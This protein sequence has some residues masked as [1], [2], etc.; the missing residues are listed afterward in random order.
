MMK[1]EM[2]RLVLVLSLPVLFGSCDTGTSVSELAENQSKWLLQTIHF[3]DGRDLRV[4]DPSKYT[5]RFNP[6][7]TASFRVDCNSCFA[8][9]AVDGNT[10]SIGLMACTLALCPEG[11][12]SDEYVGA[13]SRARSFHRQETVLRIEGGGGDLVFHLE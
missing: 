3:D 13:L 4:P 8:S 2:K 11:S 7:G 10:L 5:A 9:Y 12:L 1:P 6:D